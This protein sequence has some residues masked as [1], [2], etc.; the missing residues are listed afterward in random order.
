MAAQ[1]EQR[2]KFSATFER[3]GK[4]TN[5]KGYSED[6]LLLKNIIDVQTNIAITDHIWFTLSKGFEKLNL[7]PGMTI[8]FE[9]RIKEYKKGYVNA[10]Y[11]IN[12]RTVDFKL[13][14][15]TRIEIISGDGGR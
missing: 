3:F 4:K 12:Q 15:P 10:R 5:Y 11:K 2:K 8:T 7:Q 13:S 14:H 1:A 9:A 6:T